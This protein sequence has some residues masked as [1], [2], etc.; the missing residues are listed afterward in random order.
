MDLVPLIMGFVIAAFFLAAYGYF[1]LSYLKQRDEQAAIGVQMVLVEQRLALRPPDISGLNERL[2]KSE[3]RLEAAH[4]EL[5]SKGGL[6]GPELLDTLLGWAGE[7]R[8]EVVSTRSLPASKQNVGGYTYDVA[9]MSLTVGGEYA[10][11]SAFLEKLESSPYGNLVIRRVDLT[12]SADFFKAAIRI[13]VFVVNEEGPAP[14][15]K[16]AASAGKEGG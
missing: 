13:A 1:G 12:G 8:V 6:T 2:K 16:T 3:A 4:V 10:Q 15:A 7:T 14:G 9:P 5:S 11:V